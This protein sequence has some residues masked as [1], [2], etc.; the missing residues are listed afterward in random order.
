MARIHNAFTE[1][2][3]EELR[4]SRYVRG[5][6]ERFVFFTGEFKRLHWK[7]HEEEHLMP[8][9][10]L[11]KL[12]INCHALEMPRVRGLAQSIKHQLG[13]AKDAANAD[14]PS[15]LPKRRKRAPEQEA[16]RLRAENEH[17]KREPDFVKKFLR[18]A[19]RASDERASRARNLR[20]SV[21]TGGPSTERQGTVR[22]CGR[23]AE[24]LLRAAESRAS[25]PSPR[26][27]RPRRLR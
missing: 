13:R 19:R 20:L 3:I 25:A 9:E 21:M 14:S 5:A 16:E 23:F 22:D 2:Q 8:A 15:N 6:G 10:I 24:R 26:G 11:R 7:M 4:G 27:A 18:R 12:G 17:L 1:A